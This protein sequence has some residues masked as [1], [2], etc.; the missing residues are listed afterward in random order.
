M[1][2]EYSHEGF[3]IAEF[4]DPTQRCEFDEGELHVCTAADEDLVEGYEECEFCGGP[5]ATFTDDKGNCPD[6]F[7]EETCWRL[8]IKNG[9]QRRPD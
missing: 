3:C 4:E 7:P 9:E 1:P 8:S 5:G 2:C 6:P